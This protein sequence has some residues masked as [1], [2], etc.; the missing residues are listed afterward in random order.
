MGK[1]KEKEKA[2]P[3]QFIEYSGENGH[4]VSFK[5]PKPPKPKGFWS[6]THGKFVKFGDK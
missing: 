1:K 6:V 2:G 3:E 4:V 5:G